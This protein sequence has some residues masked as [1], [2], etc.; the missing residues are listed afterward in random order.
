LAALRAV[1]RFLLHFC[2]G[3]DTCPFDYA[4]GAAAHD[5]AND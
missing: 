3:H 2:I 1:K 5:W 4:V